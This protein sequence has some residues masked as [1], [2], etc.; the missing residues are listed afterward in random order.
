MYAASL[1]D[2][3]KIFQWLRGNDE[4]QWTD[5]TRLLSET[6]ANL[7]DIVQQARDHK[8]TGRPAAESNTFSAEANA[9]NVAMP[10]LMQMLGAMHIRSRELAIKHGEAALDLLP[11]V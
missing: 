9:I 1:M 3:K 7:Q 4:S 11:V 10:Q 2:L 5:T 6:I 8:T